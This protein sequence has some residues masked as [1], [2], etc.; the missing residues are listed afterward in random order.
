MIR[1]IP[2]C[3]FLFFIYPALAE[4]VSLSEGASISETN[5]S[6]D[7]KSILVD[8]VNVVINGTHHFENI[9][10]INY[11]SVT[12]DAG[13]KLDLIVQGTLEISNSKI[14]V[15][16]KG[17]LPD[18]SVAVFSGGSHIGAG[19]ALPGTLSALPYGDY[20]TPT[21]AGKGG[22]SDSLFIDDTNSTRGGGIVKIKANKLLLNDGS[23]AAHGKNLEGNVYAGG[24]AGGSILVEAYEIAGLG[25]IG[26]DG[27]R[28]IASGDWYE[29]N[30]GDGAGGIVSIHYEIADTTNVDLYSDFIF[31]GIRIHAY[32]TDEY[33]FNYRGAQGVIFTR[34]IS[35]SQENLFVFNRYGNYSSAEYPKN[36]TKTFLGNT[37]GI[38]E[39]HIGG[40][41][42]ALT[43][44]TIDLR[45][46]TCTKP[47]ARVFFVNDVN[48]NNLDSGS[49]NSLTYIFEKNVTLLNTNEIVPLTEERPPYDPI[50]VKI[51]GNL[52]TPGN[53]LTVAHGSLALY[54]PH[55]FNQLNIGS[56]S[57][58]T[59]LSKNETF[60][61][62]II[63]ATDFIIQEAGG[64]DV[65]YQGNSSSECV[66]SF[67]YG[68]NGKDDPN[69]GGTS[70]PYG[71]YQLPMDLGQGCGGTWH[72]GGGGVQI[73]ADH[74][75]LNG[76]IK[77]AGSGYGTGG[78]IYLNVGKLESELSGRFLSANAEYLGGGGRIAIYYDEL[79][80]FD[81]NLDSNASGWSPGTIYYKNKTTASGTLLVKTSDTNLDK[82]FLT[83][84]SIIDQSDQLV[85][86]NAKVSIHDLANFK[87]SWSFT[88]SEINISGD[89]TIA[90][91][92]ASENSSFIF[93]DNVEI[94]NAASLS[95]NAKYFFLK[96][97]TTTERIS[98]ESGLPF[99]SVKGSIVVPDENLSVDGYTL[100][101]A[102][103]Q[104]Y[105]NIEI[106]NGGVLTA[107]KPLN[108]EVAPF[109]LSAQNIVIDSTSKID[110]SGKGLAPSSGNGS[111]DGGSHGGM[112]GESYYGYG[113]PAD[114]YGEITGPVTYGGG[115]NL[116]YG[117]S[118]GGGAIKIEA[119]T[120][121]LDGHILADGEPVIN[122]FGGSAAGGSIWI[123]VK[124][125][126]SNGTGQ[127]AASG[128]AGSSR[129]VD[130]WGYYR[131]GGGGGGRI[132]VYYEEIEGIG[133]ENIHADGGRQE[134]AAQ[135]GAPGTIYLHNKLDSVDRNLFIKNPSLNPAQAQQSLTFSGADVS[136]SIKNV[137]ITNTGDVSLKRLNI[138][139]SILRM[140][141]NLSVASDIYANNSTVHINGNATINGNFTSGNAAY[142][143]V[144]GNLTVTGNT[145]LNDIRMEAYQHCEWNNIQL[146][147]TNISCQD[148][149]I[150]GQADLTNSSFL[151]N[152]NLV[153]EKIVRLVADFSEVKITDYSYSESK[154]YI[155][156]DGNLVY[157][158]ENSSDDERNSIRFKIVRGLADPFG[159]SF[160]S[161]AHPGQFLTNTSS[162]LQLRENDNSVALAESATFYVGATGSEAV[163]LK[164]MSE[165]EKYIQREDGSTRINYYDPNKSNI[166]TI[167]DKNNKDIY[168]AFPTNIE[169]KGNAEFREGISGSG[170]LTPV[171]VVDGNLEMPNDN[172]AFDGINVSLKGNHT[173]N[174][175]ELKNAAS[176][177]IVVA[178]SYG[179]AVRNGLALVAN[180][181]VIDSSSK[182]DLSEKER[183]VETYAAGVGGSH[184]GRGGN[185]GS[186]QSAQTHGYMEQPVTFGQSGAYDYYN[187]TYGGSALKLTANTLDVNGRILA[188]GEN[189]TNW[190]GAAAGG[191]I[192]LVIDSITS[193]LGSGKIQANGGSAYG[194]ENSAAGGGRI[195]IYSQTINGLDNANITANGGVQGHS[196]S[197]P[198]QN[199]TIYF[200]TSSVPPY[201]IGTSAVA[202]TNQAVDKLRITFSAPINAS[203]FTVDDIS[204]Q[205]PESGSF[206]VSSITQIS[207]TEFELNFSPALVS[208]NYTL[209]VS[210]QIAGES[211]LLLDQN[212]NL[213]GGEAEDFYTVT[214][215]VDVTPPEAPVLDTYPSI[216]TSGLQL[217]SGTKEA[218]TK[219]VIN[220]RVVVY[221]NSA[222]RWSYEAYLSPGLNTLNIVVI[223]QAGNVSQPV[224]V[225]I[226]FD[227]TPPGP[228]NVT[229]NPN[230]NGKQL[231]LDWGSY[232]TVANGNDIAF[233]R[234][235]ASTSNFSS[236]SGL[237]PVQTLSYN[238]KYATLNNLLRD[239]RYYVAVVAEDR[240]G[241]FSP[242][243]NT[244]VVTPVDTQAPT[245]IDN[246]I[247]TPTTN[248]LV[249][250]WTKANNADADL[251][252]YRIS[253]VD[254]GQPKT[255]TLN[256][257]EIGN[258]NPVIYELKGLTSATAHNLVISAVDLTGNTSAP[259]TDP[260]ITLL[261]NPQ[262][263]TAVSLPGSAEVTWSAVM[264][265]ALVKHY[266]VYTSTSLFNSV[267]GMTPKIVNKGS[268]GQSTISTTITGL[269]NGTKIYVAVTAVNNSNGELKTVVPV[270]VT[271]Q[272]DTEGPTIHSVEFIN[273]TVT[274]LLDGGP[275]LTDNGKFAVK[276][277]DKSKIARTIFTLNDEP[278]GNVLITNS[279]GAYEQT[280]DL[281]ALA[282]GNYT[283]GIK[284][285][286]MLENVTERN[287]PFTVDLIAPAIPTISVPAQ[288][289]TINQ[290]SVQLSGK[291]AAN[292]EVMIA[293]NGSDRAD[294]I[295]VDSSGNYSVT[296]DVVDGLNK[297]KTKARYSGRNKWSDYSAERSFTVN[298]QIPDAPRGFSVTA[299]KQGQMYLQWSAVT[300]SNANNQVKGYKIYRATTAFTSKND[301]GVSVINN[302][303]LVTATN[304]TNTLV[305]DGNY[306]YAVSAVNTANNEG[307]LSNVVSAIA[308]SIGPKIT[309]LT[310][311]PEGEFDAA[312][313]I[314]GRGR[315]MVSATFSEP[316][317]NTPYFAV[318]PDAGLPVSIDL[319]K[320]YT[321]EKVYTGQFMIDQSTASGMAYATMS[322]F[323]N[324]GNRGTDIQQG[325]TLKIDTQGPDI[326]QLTISPVEPLKVDT[327]NGLRV[328]V[329][330][331]LSEKTKAGTQ[332]KLVP[333]INGSVLAGYEQGI[334][335]VTTTDDANFAGEF[336]LPNTVAQS[337]SAQLSF[338]HSAADELNNTSQKILGQNQFQVYQGNLPPLNTPGDL[339]AIALPGG[340]IKLNWRAVEK[341]AGYVLYR[342]GPADSAPVALPLLTATE[343]EDAT[344]ADGTYVYAVASIRRDNGQESESSKSA[345]VSVKADRIAPA[346]PEHLALELNGAGI[347]ARWLAPAVDAQGAP[348]SQQGLTYKLYRTA[349]PQGAEVTDVSAYTP[350]Q[351]R[352][353][354]LIALDTK[355]VADQH[356]YFVVAVDAA[357]N[358]S[359]PSA[360]AYLNAGLLPVNQLFITL[361]NNGYPQLSWQHQGNGIESYRVLRK[362]GDVG[363][364]LL[365]PEGIAHTG[366]SN[367][368]V[369]NTYNGN[370][371]SQGAGQEVVYSVI[372]VDEHG[373]ESVPHELRLPALSVKLERNK[374]LLLERGV[375]NQLWFRVDNKGTHAADGIRLYVTIIENGQQREHSSD[376]F[377][378]AANANQLVP[379]VIGGYDKLD[380]ITDLSLRLE[381]KPQTNQRIHI[382][383][384]ESVDVGSSSLTLDLA[385][386]NFT[387][388]GSGKVSFNLTNNSDV[389]TELVMATNNSKADST[390][391][392]L[393][394]E[395]MQG[396]L[397]ARK[398]IR[399]TTGGVINV[400]SGHTVARVES[401]SIF[402][403]EE[404]TI[405]VPA[406]APDQ[407]RLRLVVDKYHYQ[408]G[409]ENHVEISGV[410]VSK[411]IQ[412]NDTP[413]FAIV[414][415]VQPATVNAKNGT[416]TISG[417]AVDRATNE[418]IANVP[419]SIVTSV[420]G[421]ERISTVYS[422]ASG[423]YVHS[424]KVD[425]TAGKYRISAIHPEMTDRPNQGE[426]IA[427]GGSVSPADIDGK[428]PRNYAQKIYLRV[429]ADQ[430]T[431]LTNIRL[432]QLPNAQQTIAELPVG[433]S[434]N[435]QPLAT[436]SANSYKDLTLT[437]TGDNTA[438]D[439]GLIS[440]RVEADNHTGTNALGMVNISYRLSASAPAIN[441]KPA[442]IDTGV[443]L[444]Q[445][446]SEDV[447]VT[448][449]GLD[450][451]RAADVE[452]V[453]A[454]GS[455]LP[456]WVRVPT[457]NA[458]GDIPV[459]ESRQVQIIAEPKTGVND[460]I[461]EFKLNIKGANISTYTVPVFIKV[462]QSGKGKVF[463]KV[464]DI[465]TAT[466][467]ANQQII[468]GVNKARIQLQN[469]NVL[470]EVYN[471]N[472]D[473]R[474]EALFENIPAGRYAYR[475]S[476]NDHNSV[477]GRIWIKP[478]V[479]SSEK[480]FL[481]NNLV[482]VEWS[483]REIT[484][485]DRYEIKLEA[486]FKTN[487]PAP[488]VILK[489]MAVNLPVMKKGDVFQGEFT[490]TNHGLIRAYDL[491]EGLPVTND[492][493]RFEFL[494][495]IPAALEPG[496]VFTLP[497]RIQALR[498]FNPASEAVATGGGCG[499]YSAT[500]SVA[501][502]GKCVNDAVVNSSTTSHFN[503]NWGSCG[504]GGS[505]GGGGGGL[506]GG[507]GGGGG[508]VSYSYGGSAISSEP[509]WCIADTEC[510]D[511][512][513][514]N[515]SG[516]GN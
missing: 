64:I 196:P 69:I 66:N 119:E 238:Y 331:R 291:S 436:V 359:A 279:Q 132:A 138:D 239:Q 172:A 181:V 250:S 31:S 356:N 150:K 295:A 435:Y 224:V 155:N 221:E 7:N 346:K 232:D 500:Y 303:Q 428:I 461:Y 444:D 429:R 386:Q 439:T 61:P 506:G 106:I 422:D 418:P 230:G 455:A 301:A 420:R 123:D 17:L 109:A 263:V 151:I 397:L 415:S 57:L 467:D 287:Y 158:D 219:V 340:K 166:W 308:D 516:S 72:A 53:N 86:E 469:E 339:T 454:N 489:P 235:Y 38:D 76:F 115:S 485:E 94:D 152:N 111:Y 56:N 52:N 262:Q 375:M 514:G 434:V 508:G 188:N 404:F 477:S 43:D 217:I 414:T 321:D 6:F 2:F 432:V 237:A 214:F 277:S 127:I 169:I 74:L 245:G 280:L 474:G 222:T 475:A 326:T 399:Q 112:G 451:L 244:I 12:H 103:S 410:G 286:D 396:N 173:F 210:P 18:Y 378:I 389:E 405:D 311:T 403:S 202:L 258:T 81:P 324:L 502:K 413:Y 165:P 309:Q 487:V 491:K 274:Q 458:L 293:V 194:M 241:L 322:A 457:A 507:Y 39:L 425:G 108:A 459:G 498:D 55:T 257:T 131:A 25:D 273:A 51:Y 16:G 466:K 195:A 348:Q 494:K 402:S 341:A 365:T 28:G 170:A 212:K 99:I 207:T 289:A 352:I 233:Y 334:V 358:E 15:T 270:A 267:A 197:E 211:G 117:L 1:I 285:Y 130:Y 24:G 344:M 90:N 433:I 254:Q 327:A 91:F 9:R 431:N 199:G 368:Y 242:A 186:S 136:L 163:E 175:I 264:P 449:S 49:C 128:S 513:K 92:P 486:T 288:N 275:T 382:Q 406:A 481:M 223:D 381:Q 412:L 472:T 36:S 354:A 58:L 226:N 97:L 153:A 185:K 302:G 503:S 417:R 501:Y 229:V 383:Q 462:T 206:Y 143:T 77:A 14:D 84:I 371:V 471:L 306:F 101:L 11:G 182:I 317:R 75:L 220:E 227:N 330:I 362:T 393:I 509:M 400:P 398:A 456:E 259:L 443:G 107:S 265:N 13:K 249:I 171:L 446:V 305:V 120:L 349:L 452:L 347:V 424:Y 45:I 385:T 294:V 93:N 225:E 319:A 23:I 157:V 465:Y 363:A 423:N 203:T 407:V 114:P 369:D 298:T 48:I 409:K 198:G 441:T 395:D 37:T 492:L 394:L 426:F 496:Q 384:K 438:A 145:S 419:V 44:S 231:H 168:L 27:S 30:V 228:V 351:T 41:R 479:T 70:R 323:D 367:N 236:V 515:G 335:L 113:R 102:S 284:V 218:G 460:G 192:W 110:V 139:S 63:S 427:E 300:S 377:N 350:I 60:N 355:P 281:L 85:V 83:E 3:L 464:S 177:S 448:N 307:A 478:D 118:Y 388:G 253:Y 40:A 480:I 268:S 272:D 200:K 255:I 376:I 483:V 50:S 122:S 22:R 328:N 411:D 205:D 345:T 88:N 266:A 135:S 333:T 134:Q 366:T 126:S 271:P 473:I 183:Y 116:G 193:S 180:N 213:I 149:A 96:N 318:V 256:Q 315:V 176:L 73:T 59:S 476:A 247:V 159:V 201:V 240:V 316:L 320:S 511:C 154:R 95:K 292:T 19:G 450:L 390:E 252:G 133:I 161:I 33:S 442:F 373:V 20:R 504:G 488:V 178:S 142:W 29:G 297:I 437:F 67:S 190:E 370:Q 34:Q 510:D 360:T 100:E 470:T 209:K 164:S 98:G 338:V 490:L 512:N 380:A 337:S 189:A 248:S 332:V 392:R 445:T 261:T 372:A 104:L 260:G 430:E 453:T 246:L 278:L 361:D 137:D 179:N 204:I 243:V 401:K 78:S 71:N 42:V 10:I 215:A 296:V 89:T 283:L 468:E 342:Q 140:S 105:N 299:S 329:S 495:E 357:G 124:K 251:A 216:T 129:P 505:S 336:N 167:K 208:G 314:F 5:T 8:G 463:F 269:V 147:N 290:T 364:E 160:E 144:V 379:V 21:T 484:V 146:L 447:V 82:Q 304:F 312:N 79:S 162:N 276:A 282:D 174:D 156:T 353:P 47:G 374:S 391:V 54:L 121:R 62:L 148:V 65:S 482:N 408:L 343:Y 421:F 184:G 35:T 313:N 68:G 310:F 234:V 46:N 416:V 493:V 325:G 187:K 32:G 80:G 125:L 191:S 141:G 87:E 26:A 4:E 497:Y 387:R 499:S 440:Y